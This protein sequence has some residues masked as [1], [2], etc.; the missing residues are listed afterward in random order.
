VG[1][2]WFTAVGVIW[3]V[4][5]RPRGPTRIQGEPGVLCGFVGAVVGV[6]RSLAF[7]RVGRCDGWKGVG[8]RIGVGVVRLSSVVMVVRIVVGSSMRGGGT[9]GVWGVDQRLGWG[10]V[11][12]L[13]V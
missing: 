11:V 13:G 4:V 3:V 8:V 6:V 1:G 7:V 12:V 5:V 9:R 10:V 2:G